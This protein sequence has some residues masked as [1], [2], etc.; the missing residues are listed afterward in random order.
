MMACRKTRKDK[1]KH[2]EIA[3]NEGKQKQK[4]MVDAGRM[5][6]NYENQLP[7]L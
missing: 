6:G 5:V 3:S 2:D 4:L 1:Q 7:D